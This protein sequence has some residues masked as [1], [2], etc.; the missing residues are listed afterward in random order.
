MNR[1]AARRRTTETIAEAF[2]EQLEAG[3]MLPTPYSWPIGRTQTED[4]SPECYGM[5]LKAFEEHGPKY[6]QEQMSIP[7]YVDRLPQEPVCGVCRSTIL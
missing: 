7:S 5:V 2:P 1:D 6:V 3:S 4:L